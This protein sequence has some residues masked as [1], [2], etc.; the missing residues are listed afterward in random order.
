MADPLR[1]RVRPG[2]G[3]TRAVWREAQELP[4]ARVHAHT[5][6]AGL[7]AGA[8]NPETTLR[9]RHVELGALTLGGRRIEGEAAV[10]RLSG[11]RV[12]EGSL[13]VEGALDVGGRL[14]VGQTASASEVLPLSAY[15]TDFGVPVDRSVFYLD[16]SSAG[17]GCLP[18][19]GGGKAEDIAVLT[20]SLERPCRVWAFTR[21][22]RVT[23]P[24]LRLN[25]RWDGEDRPAALRSDL[26][27]AAEHSA[28]E[29]ADPLARLALLARVGEARPETRRLV[30]ARTEGRDAVPVSLQAWCVLP[31]GY[32]RLLLEVEPGAYRI[33][34]GHLQVIC[35]PLD[36]GAR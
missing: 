23:S 3:I 16:T 5:H 1:H 32:S 13:S 20:L 12:L 31:A 18:A 34:H 17:S 26:L 2:D 19:T 11:D 35:I 29:A 21:F 15:A 27:S 6:E 30:P 22:L 25:L 9:L 24:A 28:L 7:S 36:G 4:R 10:S 14:E 8:L 33:G